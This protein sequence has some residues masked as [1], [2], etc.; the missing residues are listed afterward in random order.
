MINRNFFFNNCRSLFLNGR[1][2]QKQ[3]DGITTI[4]DEW[5]AHHSNDDDRWLAYMLATVHHETNMTFQPIEEIGKGRG[6]PY[7]ENLKMNKRTRYTN[8]TNLFYGRGFVQLTWYDNYEK[9]GQ[10]LGQDFINHPEL[11]MELTNSTKILFMGMIGG[12][13]TGKKLAN[14]FNATKEDWKG[15]RRIINGTDK[16]ALIAN[17]ALSYYGSISYTV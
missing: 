12:L 10:L 7:G 8:T 4:L 6:K 3:V 17:L 5:E 11:V 2:T 15:A 16:N 13:F 1:L 14:Y 9:M